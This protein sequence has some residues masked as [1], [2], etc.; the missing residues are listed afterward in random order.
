MT[1]PNNFEETFFD[2]G[3][4]TRTATNNKRRYTQLASAAFLLVVATA[5]ATYFITRKMMESAG[6]PAAPVCPGSNATG[7]VTLYNVSDRTTYNA[8]D[9]TSTTSEV[10]TQMGQWVCSQLLCDAAAMRNALALIL[11]FVNRLCINDPLSNQ[12]VNMSVPQCADFTHSAVHVLIK[13]ACRNGLTGSITNLDD[14]RYNSSNSL[15][16]DKQRR[17]NITQP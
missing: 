17:F 10:V 7:T 9:F 1:W 11:P 14:D 8:T 6:N 5:L 16:I 3:S 12:F 2:S 15:D 4:P 13:S